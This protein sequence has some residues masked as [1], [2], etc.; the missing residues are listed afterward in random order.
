MRETGLTVVTRR[1]LR[2]LADALRQPP[3]HRLTRTPRGMHMQAKPSAGPRPAATHKPPS[4]PAP[5]RAT[6]SVAWPAPPRALSQRCTGTHVQAKS[7][8]SAQYPR[9]RSPNLATIC[10]VLPLSG[11][12]SLGMEY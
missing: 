10:H 4:C 12:S 5:A 7:S 2:A 1:S 11:F 8:A 6:R 3:T 9:S